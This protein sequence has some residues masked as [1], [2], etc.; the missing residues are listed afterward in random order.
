MKKKRE[1]QDVREVQI[2]KEE[3]MKRK[4][5]DL[6]DKMAKVENKKNIELEAFS[7]SHNENKKFASFASSS[8]AVG[9]LYPDQR[10]LPAIKM[11]PDFKKETT[12]LLYEPPPSISVQ[13]YD[14]LPSTSYQFC[15]PVDSHKQIEMVINGP[16]SGYCSRYLETDSTNKK[17]EKLAKKY[18]KTE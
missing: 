9:G 11:R 12:N 7:K 2:I 1:K 6:I 13:K 3:K 4:N 5:H 14:E 15:A 18:C 17:W 8:T 16:C 10:V